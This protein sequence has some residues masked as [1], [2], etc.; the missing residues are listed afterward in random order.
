[1]RSMMLPTLLEN[2][3]WLV[4]GDLTYMLGRYLFRLCGGLKGARV[5]DLPSNVIHVGNRWCLEKSS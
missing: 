5:R 4:V 1:M 2:K 3:R